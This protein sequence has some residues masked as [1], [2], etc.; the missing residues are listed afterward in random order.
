MY[1]PHLQFCKTHS[2]VANY[3]ALVCSILLL[4]NAFYLGDLDQYDIL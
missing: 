1:V 3:L 4:F 2:S